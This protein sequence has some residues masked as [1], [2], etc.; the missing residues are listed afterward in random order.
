VALAKRAKILSERQ[1]AAVLVTLQTSGRYSTR[2]VAMF[3]LS[4][5]AGL[6]AKEIS[7]LTWSMLTDAEGQIA[8]AISLEN[9][10]SKGKKGGRTIPMNGQLRRALLALQASESGKPRAEAPVIRSERGGKMS[11]GSI[12]DWFGDLYR[13]IGMEG[14]SSHSGRR[15]FITRVARRISQVGGSLRDVQALAGHSSIATTQGYIDGE[16]EAQIKVVDLV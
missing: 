13:G 8:G 4:V 12:A 9:K 6:R 5:K 2:N 14:C 1:E 11:P 15:T 16:A 10:A 3:L 7:S